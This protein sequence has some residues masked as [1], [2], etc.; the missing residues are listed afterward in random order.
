M[1][2][3]H[4]PFGVS[5]WKL[6]T[7]FGLCCGLWTPRTLHM[8]RAAAKAKAKAGQSAH[9]ALLKVNENVLNEVQIDNV[10]YYYNYYY[11]KT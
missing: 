1:Y 7:F 6:I 11:Y 4:A 2:T 8:C 5:S 9:K 3:A 10:Y